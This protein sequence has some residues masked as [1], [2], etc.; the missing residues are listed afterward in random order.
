MD[1][2]YNL[3]EILRLIIAGVFLALHIISIISCKAGIFDVI[4]VPEPSPV[5]KKYADL[6]VIDVHNHDAGRYRYKKAMSLWDAYGIDQVVL[7]AGK[8]SDPEGMTQDE[9]ACT[10][11][12]E[13]PNRIL[14]FFTGF[15]VNNKNSLQYVKEQF[16]KG[17]L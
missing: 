6:K 14:P 9:I 5:A 15:D 11:S 16:D 1:K 17:F 2:I 3:F 7:F 10:A 4:E 8:I 12:Q 13:Y